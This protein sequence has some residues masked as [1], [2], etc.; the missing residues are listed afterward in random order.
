[1]QLI[2]STMKAKQKTSLA[3]VKRLYAGVERLYSLY[4]TPERR[5]HQVSPRERRG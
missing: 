1:M 4:M 5:R 3:P 2:Q